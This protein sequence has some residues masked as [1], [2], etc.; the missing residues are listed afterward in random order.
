MLSVVFFPCL[1]KTDRICGRFQHWKYFLDALLRL[2]GAVDYIFRAIYKNVCY[3]PRNAA[4]YVKINAVSLL[5]PSLSNTN[6]IFRCFRA[7]HSP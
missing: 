4:S 1:S 7:F 2:T 3:I 5:F 6:S